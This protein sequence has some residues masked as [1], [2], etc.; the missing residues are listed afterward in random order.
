MQHT[1]SVQK[2]VKW[3]LGMVLIAA[4][5]GVMPA[6]AFAKDSSAE[7]QRP[8]TPEITTRQE[9][10]QKIEEYR[11]N[12]KLYAIK[13]TPS[14]GEPYLLVDHSGD[15]NFQMERNLRIAVPQWT[16]LRW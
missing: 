8:P 16:L 15:G 1:Q 9:Q 2:R 13:I 10:D 6:G 12:G 3:A 7:Q 11:I 4:A 14:R 5:C